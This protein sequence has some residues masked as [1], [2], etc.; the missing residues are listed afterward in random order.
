MAE[1]Q[2]LAGLLRSRQIEQIVRVEE[3]KSN[4]WTEIV[5]EA[6]TSARPQEAFE[7]AVRVYRERN[8]AA[9]LDNSRTNREHIIPAGRRRHVRAHQLAWFCHRRLG[10]RY[11]GPFDHSVQPLAYC[12]CPAGPGSAASFGPGIRAKRVT[13]RRSVATICS[14]VAAPM[15]TAVAAPAPPLDPPGVTDGSRGLRVRPCRALSV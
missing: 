10:R 9:T 15:P 3:P 5:L 7:A 8:P 14:A 12:R 2:E 1:V 4:D 6:Y 13:L 11:H